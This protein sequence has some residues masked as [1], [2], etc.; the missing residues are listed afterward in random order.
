M[1]VENSEL[2][3]HVA[4]ASLNFALIK[5]LINC[6]SILARH[7]TGYGVKPGGTTLKSTMSETFQLKLTSL[8]NSPLQHSFERLM[9]SCTILEVCSF[10]N[11]YYNV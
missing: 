5:I 7:F 6:Q 9:A 2:V 10:I 11:N 4:N 8:R 3:Q 1:Q